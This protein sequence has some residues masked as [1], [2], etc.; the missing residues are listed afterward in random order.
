MVIRGG[1][2]GGG[3]W[4]TFLFLRYSTPCRHKGTFKKSSFARPTL[5]FFQRRLRRQY[6]LIL[7]GSARGGARGG[8]ARGGG[9]GSARGG[10]RQYILIFRSKFSKKCLKTPF[11]PIFSKFCLRR[12]K[13]GQN[14]DKTVLCRNISLVD[15]QIKKRSTKFSKIF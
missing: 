13:F 10:A 12:R 4:R 3:G 8:S 6:I 7:R 5:I 1:F 9:G 14:R 15:Y 11:W 2:R